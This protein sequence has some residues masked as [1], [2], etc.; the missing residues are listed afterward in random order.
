MIAS[1]TRVLAVALLCSAAHAQVA[2]GTAFTYQGQLR[3]GD[4]PISGMV[5]LEFSICDAYEDGNEL[6]SIDLPGVE[7]VNGLFTVSHDFGADVFDGSARWLE[8]SVR[9]P[10]GVGDYTLLNPRQEIT[11]TPYALALPGLR[12]QQNDTSPNLIGGWINNTVTAGVAGATIS[13]GGGVITYPLPNR[14]TDDYGTTGGGVGNI[15][16]ND[17]ESAADSGFATVGGGRTNEASAESATVGGGEFNSAHGRAATVGGGKSNVAGPEGSVHT[18]A[19]AT[20]SGGSRNVAYSWAAT[21][22]GG[23]ENAALGGMSTVPGGSNNV[24][25]G[26]YSFA[27]GQRAWVRT[28]ADVGDEDT[29]GDEG[30][31]VWADSTTPQ[32]SYFTSTAPDQF[33]VLASGGVGIGTNSPANALTV[34]GNADF[35]GQVGIGTPDPG[36]VITD[37]MLDVAGGHIGLSNDYGVFSSNSAGNGIGAGLDTRSDDG[38]D[39]YAGGA[40]RVLITPD[41]NV[42]IGTSAPTSRLHS[43]HTQGGA[44]TYPLKLA[45]E[46]NSEGTAAGMLFQVDSGTGRG[47]GGIVYERTTSWNRGD[48]H[49]LQNNSG[50]TDAATVDDAVMT[51]KRGGWIGMGTQEPA[52]QLDIT[53]NNTTWTGVNIK[54]L[55]S[56]Q[57][58]LIQVNGTGPGVDRAGNLEIWGSGADGNHNVF[59]AASNGNVGIRNQTPQHPLQIGTTTADGNQAHLTA[60]GVWTNGSD[61]NS[62]RGLKEIDAKSILAKVVDLPLTQWQYKGEDEGI[63]HIGPMAQ[64]FYTAFGFGGSNKHIGTVDADG[65]A[66][67]A[68]QGLHEL[69]R[70]KEKQI[71]ALRA[72]KDAEIAAQQEQIE[73][74]LG[75]ELGSSK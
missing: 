71:D 44:L 31:F 11:P 19:Y 23:W 60:G 70:E 33:L 61:R 30:T 55:A 18:A 36:N 72:E 22:G 14:V 32:G 57:R 10:S 1:S 13:G 51:I 56:S 68:I 46:G 66:L 41:G 64:D 45:N 21:V 54:N 35:D 53:S 63:Q 26:Q 73:I 74:M 69:V 5:D 47:K 29:N 24:A 50:N 28:A 59:T 67:G 27:A 38:L 3:Q 4:V 43:K 42:G 58:Y 52:A 40:S 48:L 65:V 15:A 12:T 17:D 62:R 7:V 37:A 8:V 6:G 20:V 16:G 2:T 39:L 9:F 34:A 49:I 25:G 75:R